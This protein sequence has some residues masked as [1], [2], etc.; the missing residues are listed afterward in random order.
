MA[1]L[2]FKIEYENGPVEEVTFRPSAQVAYETDTGDPIATSDDQ[3]LV[4]KLYRMAWYAAG[5]PDTF[6]E[7]LDRI[8]SI[9]A[10]DSDEGQT[11]GDDT[12]PT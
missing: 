8:E 3:I 6:E 11:E 9:E 10:P 4:T 5:Q 7:W 12:R 1:A 2:K